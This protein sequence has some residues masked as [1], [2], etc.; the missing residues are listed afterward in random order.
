MTNKFQFI[1]SVHSRRGGIKFALKS[2]AKRRRDIRDPGYLIE[3]SAIEHNRTHNKIWSIEHNRTFDCRTVENR[4]QANVQ[5][6]TGDNRTQSSVHY[7]TPA[8]TFFC[9]FHLI[10]VDY[11]YSCMFYLFSGVKRW[12]PNK[13]EWDRVRLRSILFDW[14]DNRTHNKI[15]IRFCSITEPNRTIGVRLNFGSILFDYWPQE[16]RKR[17][18]S[19]ASIFSLNSERFLFKIAFLGNK[20]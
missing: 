12:I 17:F 2:E 10:K 3:R 19:R 11:D 14:F 4:T 13:I 5:Y 6:R 8:W 1:S 16:E 20:P 15:D 18:R 9:L 7:W